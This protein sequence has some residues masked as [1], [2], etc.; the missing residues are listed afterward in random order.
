MARRFRYHNTWL[1][2]LVT[3]ALSL[4]TGSGG[5]SIAP[6]LRFTNVIGRDSLFTSLM[7]DAG[8]FSTGFL[9]DPTIWD[10]IDILIQ[11]LQYS[12]STGN[13]APTDLLSMNESGRSKNGP[14][15]MMAVSC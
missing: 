6:F 13:A 7:I 1:G 3:G 15:S 9:L 4:R 10:K 11:T 2:L 8:V 5:S 12:F 14:I